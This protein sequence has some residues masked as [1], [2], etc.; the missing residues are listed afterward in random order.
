MTAVARVAT[1][2]AT[3]ARK[4]AATQVVPLSAACSRSVAAEDDAIGHP[5]LSSTHQQL[6]QFLETWETREKVI[7]VGLGAR[8]HECGTSTASSTAWRGQDQEQARTVAALWT[9]ERGHSG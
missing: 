8:D 5:S 2:M 1:Q 6:C 4:A 7:T 3:N 9:G